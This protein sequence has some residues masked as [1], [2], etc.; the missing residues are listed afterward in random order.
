MALA[1][2]ALAGSLP[3]SMTR[4]KHCA[5]RSAPCL[6]LIT[7]AS[8]L[9]PGELLGGASQ[10]RHH[11]AVHA[12]CVACQKTQSSKHNHCQDIAASPERRQAAQHGA[13]EAAHALRTGLGGRRPRRHDLCD[14][15]HPEAQHLARH[16][17]I[18][19]IIH[20][21]T[22]ACMHACMQLQISSQSTRTGTP[23]GCCRLG[24]P[25]SAGS[26]AACWR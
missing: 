23:S 12:S 6:A 9:P 5:S 13:Q 14:V 4:R 25:R 24:W 20:A 3:S 21:L 17:L 8:W 10:G 19:S 26:R 18:V 1:C 7:V 22:H 16:M 15:L 2:S 11:F